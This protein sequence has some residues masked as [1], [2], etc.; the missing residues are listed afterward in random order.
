MFT[1]VNDLWFV[2]PPFPAAIQFFEVG[3]LP[4]FCS[5]RLTGVVLP[6]T[7]IGIRNAWKAMTDPWC[8]YGNM[9][10]INIPPMLA[11]IYQHHGSYGYGSDANCDPSCDG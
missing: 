6:C 8:C 5:I 1:Y 4:H 11:S 10:P 7:R 9:D 3:G 2:S